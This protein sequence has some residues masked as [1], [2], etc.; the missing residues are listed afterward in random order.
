MSKYLRVRFH[1][2]EE[3]YRCI[4]FPPPGPYW[5]S[6]YGED[7]SV[8]VAYV[9]TE[10]QILEFWPDATEVEILQE[11]DEIIFTDRFPRPDWWSPIESYAN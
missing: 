6:G 4:K 3:D 10:A 7:Y 11:R 2:N 5:C 1:A 9:K 8:I